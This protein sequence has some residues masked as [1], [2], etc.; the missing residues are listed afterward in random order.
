MAAAHLLEVAIGSTG[1]WAAHLPLV[2]MEATAAVT[3]QGRQTLR[4]KQV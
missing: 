3:K 4:R 1:E 2:A